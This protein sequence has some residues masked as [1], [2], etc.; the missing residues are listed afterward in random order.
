MLFGNMAV[1]G[2]VKNWYK[3]LRWHINKEIMTK[4]IEIKYFIKIIKIHLFTFIS[5][6]ILEKEILLYIHG[7]K[8]DKQKR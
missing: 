5:S 8:S 1:S 2:L 3:I 4:Y 7:F 6:L